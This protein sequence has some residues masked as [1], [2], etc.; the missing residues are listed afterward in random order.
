FDVGKDDGERVVD[1]VREAGRERAD[2][3]DGGRRSEL[4]LDQLL[5]RQVSNEAEVPAP[6]STCDDG[7]LRWNDA[8]ILADHARLEFLHRGGR[9]CG[10]DS[11]AIGLVDQL[12]KR[13]RDDV[14]RREVE[15]CLERWI[16]GN[17]AST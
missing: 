11:R 12:E 16:Y 6:V 7:E 4:A 5:P 10:G 13:A 3:G 8:A 1:L 17:E 9:K 15:E 14:T 2:R